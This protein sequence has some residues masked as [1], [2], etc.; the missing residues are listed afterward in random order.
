MER[1]VLRHLSGSKANQVEEFPLNHVPEVI[2]GRDPSST[3]KY[4]P[5]R[6]DLVGRQHARI[7]RD[8]ADPT[9]FNISD[10]Q[11][12]NGTYV[13]KQRI[14]GT[15]RLVPGDIIQLGPG[16]PEVQFDLEP[17][18]AHSGIRAT[19]EAMS[20]PLAPTTVGTDPFATTPTTRSVD[21]GAMV[22]SSDTSN[23]PRK[24]VGKATVERM[25]SETITQT[26]KTEG[27]RYMTIGGGALIGVLVLFGG[28]A[29][30]LAYRGQASEAELGKVQKE[31]AGAPMS[32]T[33]IVEANRTAV[34]KIEVSWKLMA[35]SGVPVYRKYGN[36][37]RNPK[38]KEKTLTLDVSKEAI[39]PC[40]VKLKNGTIEPFLTTENSAS[41]DPVSGQ[42]TGT[43]FVVSSDG[44]ILTTRFNAY[45]WENEYPIQDFEYALLYD[46][47]DRLFPKE[48]L[49]K[50]ELIEKYGDNVRQSWVP[51]RMRQ[52]ID[53]T[54]GRLNGINDSLYV[55]FPGS[56]GRVVGQLIRGSDEQDVAMI[57]VSLPTPLKTA[58]F[59]PDDVGSIKQGDRVAMLGY[60]VDSVQEYII[61]RRTK[62]AA[63]SQQESKIE[64]ANPTSFSGNI[65]RIL[66]NQ[67]SPD[68]K[69]GVY[70]DMGDVYQLTI[71]AQALGNSGSPIFD[72]KGRV[73]A[74]FSVGLETNSTRTFAVPI[75][76]GKEL[77]VGPPN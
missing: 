70:S 67:E 43:G 41:T 5:D 76:Y 56:G 1:I 42:Y 39:Y 36:F 74:I 13:N 69:S 58:Q 66:K 60:P 14:V 62:L 59:G 31:I 32:D 40:F 34:V 51:K 17:R 45:A 38:K 75:R 2:L 55:T 18:P 7:A 64:V 9:L 25:I 53:G 61:P 26:K 35:P 71:N 12:R 11:S 68:N 63:N 3:V 21:A 6:D 44:Y 30:Y 29:G 20:D 24:T 19:R 50:D 72:D 16:G 22:S 27:R 49:R 4:D 47:T 52:N 65:G 37:V 46:D 73:I 15:A 77:M 57:K 33:Q 23:Q 8:S 28:I 10:L 54:S 48:I